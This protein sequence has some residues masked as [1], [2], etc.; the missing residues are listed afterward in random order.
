MEYDVQYLAIERAG[1]FFYGEI[2][3]NRA[4]WLGIDLDPFKGRSEPVSRRGIEG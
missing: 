4:G 2:T 3:R 1:W